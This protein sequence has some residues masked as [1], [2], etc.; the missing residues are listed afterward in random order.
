MSSGQA[1]QICLKVYD[2]HS[3][4]SRTSEW[5]VRLDPR[6]ANKKT[7]HLLLKMALKPKCITF[8]CYGTLVQWHAALERGVRSILVRR[9]I[10]ASGSGVP[11]VEIVDALRRLAMEKQQGPLYL[12]YKTILRASLCEA[13]TRRGLMPDSQDGD[14][15]LSILRS[16]PPHPEV[17]A[18]LQRLREHFRLAIISNSDDDLISATVS[19][20][21]VP[22]DFVVTAEQAHAYKPD[23]RLFQ[24]AH[25]VIGVSAEETLHVGM[26]QVTDLKVCHEMGIRVVWINRLR[27]ALNPDWEPEAVLPDLGSLPALLTSS[28]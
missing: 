12:D 19:S 24:H 11:V 8:D 18:A 3:D 2:P 10:A 26:G 28:L 13:M 22:I 15:L 1:S 7:E 21:G 23:H 27:E 9:Q 14:A 20:L 5:M 4:D 17:P 25:A 6:S 16:I